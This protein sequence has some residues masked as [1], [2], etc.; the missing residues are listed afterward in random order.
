MKKN[1]PVTG[2][3]NDY[4]ASTTIISTTDLKGIIVTGNDDFQKVSGY[5]A[6]ELIGAN[7]NIVRHPD[8]PPAAFDNLWSDLKADN[9]WLGIVNNRSKNGDHYWVEAYVGPIV[10]NGKK[11]GYESVRFK[12]DRD[13]VRRAEK[14]Y[15]A[16]NLGKS[17][18]RAL[19]GLSF[20]THLILSALVALIPALAGLTSLNF[21]GDLAGAWLGF[22]CTALLSGIA[23]LVMARPVEKLS[24]QAMQ[25]NKNAISRWVFTGRND[26]FGWIQLAL[27][28]Q[29]AKIR[30]LSGRL[31]QSSEELVAA[32]ADTTAIAKDTSASID[33]Q[34]VEVDQVATAIE[35]MSATIQEVSINT[36]AAATQAGE[37]K[38]QALRIDSISN[39]TIEAMEKLEQQVRAAAETIGKLA[40]DS[41]NIGGVLEVIRGIADQTNLLALNAAIEAA[42]AGEAGQGFAVVADEV[43]NLA[44]RTAEST[45]E[46]N[47]M[48]EGFQSV[49]QVSVSVMT[50]ACQQAQNSVGLVAEANKALR[51]ITSAIATI[52]DMTA[53][54]ATAS[55]EQSAVSS[56]INRSIHEIS[57]TQ[58]RTAADAEKT[59][60]ASGRL[61]SMAKN[62]RSVVSR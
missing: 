42:R 20:R 3:E 43:R 45:E 21:G 55:E 10:E 24:A 9:Y 33:K 32:A 59:T 15:A 53:Q 28:A 38:T 13:I 18:R 12:P 5:R 7:H 34:R 58:N 16:I 25:I 8:M 23:A 35:Q 22:A 6:E 47:K 56:E 29:H 36:A 1:L 14:F 49:A 11:I 19:G 46:I 52:S 44:T 30:T 17:P 48:V 51:E 4:P 2:Q 40:K 37:A 31:D 57:L 50:E 39:A 62:M 41:K 54:I 61:T 26:E 27:R 60:A